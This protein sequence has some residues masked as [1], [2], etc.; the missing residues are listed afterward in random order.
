MSTKYYLIALGF[1]SLLCC[2][3]AQSI[4]LQR[5]EYNGNK[6]LFEGYYV[7]QGHLHYSPFFLYRNGIY[8]SCGHVE[9]K[10]TDD[11]LD[12]LLL[13]QGFRERIRNSQYGWGVFQIK[14]ETIIIEEWLHGIGGSYPSQIST[15]GIKDSK[16]IE[17]RG[18]SSYLPKDSLISYKFR[19]LDSK[20]DSTTSFIR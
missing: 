7:D 10:Y 15:G 1:L 2:K 4:S 17:I 16:T 13:D 14:D 11:Q 3:S 18:I 20:P 5:A 12:S 19:K 6:L 8:L 9:G